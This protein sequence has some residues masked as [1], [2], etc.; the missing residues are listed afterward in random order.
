MIAGLGFHKFLQ[1]GEGDPLDLEACA[2]IPIA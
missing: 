2:R 1:E